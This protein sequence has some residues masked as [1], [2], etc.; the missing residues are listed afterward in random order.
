MIK[1]PVN[2]CF[3]YMHVPVVYL[4]MLAEQNRKGETIYH[5]IDIKN[6]H[7]SQSGIDFSCMSQRSFR[8]F[9]S[10]MQS[11]WLKK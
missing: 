9:S 8:N 5:D 6:S 4:P 10:R 2:I 3:I 11:A 1:K 7:L